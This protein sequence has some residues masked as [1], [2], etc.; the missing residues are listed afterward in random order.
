MA[1]VT[2]DRDSLRIVFAFQD[3]LFTLNGELK[4]PLAHIIGIAPAQVDVGAPRRFK[5]P[6]IQAP[7]AM[8]AGIYINE[9]GHTLWDVANIEKAVAIYFVQET[10]FAAVVEV[11]N[12]EAVIAAVTDALAVHR[13]G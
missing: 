2:L 6:S 7:R 5:M 8:M 4:I 10:Y 3:R 12:P 13:R 1:T 9:L 11:D